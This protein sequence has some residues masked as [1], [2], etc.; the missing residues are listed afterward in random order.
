MAQRMAGHRKVQTGR[1]R[2]PKS[3]SL[4]ESVAAELFFFQTSTIHDA[5]T[6]LLMGRARTGVATTEVK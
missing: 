2:L 1:H 6:L 3:G 5:L 4:I